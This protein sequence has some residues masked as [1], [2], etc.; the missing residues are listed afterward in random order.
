MASSRATTIARL[1]ELLSTIETSAKALRDSIQLEEKDLEARESAA[2]S[3]H[4]ANNLGLIFHGDPNT[5]SQ[6]SVLRIACERLGH[7]VTP[8]RHLVFEAAGSFYTTVAL[9]IVLK[10]D[11]AALINAASKDYEKEGVSVLDLAQKC[12]LDADLLARVLR[13]LSQHGMFQELA[14]G[15][16]SN[17]IA[18]ATMVDNPEF[19]AHLDLVMYEGQLAAPY[20]ERF[21]EE[22]FATSSNAASAVG[23]PPMSAFAL[24]SGDVPIY[25][26]LHLAPNADRGKNFDLA[27]RGMGGT[28]G[29]AFLPVDYPFGSLPDETV[30]VDVGGG[31]GSLAELL[32]QTL[33][34]IKFVVQDLEAVVSLA[35]NVASPN[36]KKW[37]A[38]G[39]VTFQVQDFCSP[40]PT[41]LNGAVFVLKNVI[42]NYPDSKALEILAALAPSRP[43]KLLLIDRMTNPHF[44]TEATTEAG[45]AEIYRKM[46][47]GIQ[48]GADAEKTDGGIAT[49]SQG[50]PTMYDL[51]M[52]SLHGGRTRTL[53]EWRSVLSRGG[54]KLLKVY[55]LRASTGQAV[56]EAV[57]I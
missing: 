3:E 8:P 2:Y 41:N 4:I 56:L 39:K 14:P 57:P 35:N 49:T 50:I 16:F 20:F 43:S 11:I 12:R 40:Q 36:M 42:H 22:R 34:N 38:E 1:S 15:M 46:L 52:G 7:L 33:Q 18:S 6:A 5:A 48:H 26:W 29:L 53:E 17:T 25:K 51:I 23:E 21:M 10:H 54:F 30:L 44:R 28:E 31:I 24:F 27:M 47:T 32:L 19:K 55:P 13:Y 37:I 45:E 9:Q